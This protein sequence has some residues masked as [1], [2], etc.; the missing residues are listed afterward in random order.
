M[1]CPAPV[2]EA[3][4]AG[5]A[6]AGITATLAPFFHNIPELLVNAHLV[7]ARAGGS[8]V[9]ELA[10]IGRPAILIPLRIND[11]QRANAEAL[12]QAGGAL[13]VEQS[14]GDAALAAAI[15]TLLNDP[16]RLRS[17]AAAAGTFAITD[18][19]ERLAELTLVAIAQA[20]PTEA[21]L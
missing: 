19:A 3:A 7:V 17:M 21:A 5:L 12:V 2:L 4:R 10:V 18:A 14:E 9:A 16:E 13:R 11:D 6:A 8:T 20:G 1:Q 15:E